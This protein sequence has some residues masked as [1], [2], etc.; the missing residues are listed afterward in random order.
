MIESYGFSDSLELAG[1]LGRKIIVSL[2][3][4]SS[5]HGIHDGRFSFLD[6]ISEGIGLFR[7]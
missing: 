4:E 3:D 1:V 5:R 7:V 6:L 2:G